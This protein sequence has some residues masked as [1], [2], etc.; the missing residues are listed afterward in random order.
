[1]LMRTRSHVPRLVPHAHAYTYP[2]RQ[3][4]PLSYPR[5][6][7]NAYTLT[8]TTPRI[9]L[10]AGRALVRHARRSSSRSQTMRRSRGSCRRRRSA[11][12]APE[13]R[14][15]VRRSAARRA[16]SARRAKRPRRAARKR[17]STH[18]TSHLTLHL[19]SHLTS[20]LTFPSDPPCTQRGQPLAGGA[21]P[22]RHAVFELVRR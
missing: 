11:T 10:R 9:D 17:S 20:Q 19:T 12:A 2:R 18:L 16:K 8:R 15:A 3:R 14:R 4:P 7:A 1:M 22:D 6:H 21:R 5:V 13:H